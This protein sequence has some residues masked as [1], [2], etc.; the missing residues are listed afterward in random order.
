MRASLLALCVS[1]L[2]TSLPAQPGPS[3]RQLAD[4][5]TPLFDGRTLAGWEQRN[6]SATYRVE[7]G[8]IVGR[9]APGSP[10]SF[11]CT[12]GIYDDFELRFEVKLDE[13]LNS[14]VQVRSRTRGGRTG[15][16]NGPQVEIEGSG[17][18]GGDAGYIY[19]EACGGWTM[20]R[21]MRRQHRH[22]VDGEWNRYRVRV[23]GPRFLVWV[24]GVPV[25]DWHSEALARSHPRGFIGLQ[26]HSVPRGRGP[27][28]VRWR[29]IAIRRLRRQ[30][31]GWRD[32]V[33]AAPEACFR[34][35]EGVLL[36]AREAA[37]ETEALRSEREA[38]ACELL[39][40]ASRWGVVMLHW[41]R[42]RLLLHV[43]FGEG[44]RPRLRR[45]VAGWVLTIPVHEG[46][47]GAWH[48]LEV[49]VEGGLS[50]SL[51]GLTL[52]EREPLKPVAEPLPSGTG[53]RV[54]P[55]GRDTVLE[56][57]SCR[58]RVRPDR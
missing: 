4:A 24:N 31:G 44:E 27:F 25:L 57:A 19:G 14:G 12:R 49:A 9:T 36:H 54:A 26:V 52:L 13:G 2:P 30:A 41:E 37:E 15:R 40:R 34:S 33:P 10:N 21:A 48:R 5:W 46:R 55:A 1:L 28:E 20:P 43:T 39:L 22:F 29:G 3:I 35:G 38:T 18:R 56:L 53:F 23:E 16:V 47:P 50:V 58:L 11:L 32:L 45:S 17:E 42:R 6:G 51:D 7:E 8:A